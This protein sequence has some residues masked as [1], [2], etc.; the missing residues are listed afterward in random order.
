MNSIHEGNGTCSVKLESTGS[1]VLS[2]ENNK[3]GLLHLIGLVGWQ[4][5]MFLLDMEV[6]DIH[7]LHSVYKVTSI[8]SS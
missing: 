8:F 3:Y 6:Y 5:N 4:Q 7:D 1:E 2:L